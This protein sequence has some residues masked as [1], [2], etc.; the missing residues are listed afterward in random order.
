MKSSTTVIS[1]KLDS[2]P[3]ASQTLIL[4]TFSSRGGGHSDTQWLPNGMQS[5]SGERQ[6]I[7]AV[8][9]FEGKKEGGGGG[10]VNFK[11]RTL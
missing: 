2:P 10:V 4:N 3:P 11:I 9:C 5:S 1:N 6:N 8:N 7:G